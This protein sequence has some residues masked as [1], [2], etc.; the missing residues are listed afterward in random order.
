MLT[1]VFFDLDATLVDF[2]PDA[3]RASVRAVCG[4]L[5]S[6][7]PGLD[8]ALLA[9]EYVTRYL[10]RARA[11]G[12][13]AQHPRGPIPS[14]RTA[15]L[16]L[17][18]QALTECGHPELAGTAVDAYIEQR[19]IDYALYGDVLGALRELRA[20]RRTI[21]VITNGPGDAQHAKIAATGLG[22]Y[23]DLVVVSGEVETAKPGR[24]I[25]DLALARAGATAT[26]ACHVGD[27]LT[28]DVAG[29]RAAGLG[30]AIWLDRGERDP[31]PGGNTGAHRI[32][33]LRALPTLL[34]DI[35]HG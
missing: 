10:A 26:Q 18:R 33:T 25:F 21:G 19:S 15:W 2:G 12:P 16:G 30:A 35:E 28:A 27:S 17:W 31:A 32:D 9:D 5:A 4:R 8:T 14:A 1:T 3:W 22:P 23:L 7:T 13:G 6:G 24:E 20:E 11:A 34:R 29:A